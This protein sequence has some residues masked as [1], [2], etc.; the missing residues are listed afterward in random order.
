[1][2]HRKRI[3]IGDSDQIGVHYQH[4]YAQV[5]A[6]LSPRKLRAVVGRGSAKTTEIQVDRLMKVVLSMPGAPLCWVADTFSNLASN[7][8]P[9]VLEGLE[10]K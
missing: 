9:G 2:A 10:R 1:M 7:I 6:L 4:P 5:L 3:S 8:L